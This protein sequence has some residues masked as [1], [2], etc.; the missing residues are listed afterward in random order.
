MAVLNAA[1]I[2]FGTFEERTH[3]E[4]VSQFETNVFGPVKIVR[5]VL[6]SMRERRTGLIVN[7]GSIGSSMDGPA[8]GIYDSTKAFV[9]SKIPGLVQ[10]R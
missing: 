1:F 10:C 4:L 5:A 8:C 9:K 2:M 7:I 6:P 3:E